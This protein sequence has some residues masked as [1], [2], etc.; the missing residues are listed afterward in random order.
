MWISDVFNFFNFSNIKRYDG[1]TCDKSSQ[2]TMQK[3]KVTADLQFHSDPGTQYMS[4]EYFK[5]I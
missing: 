1:E 3:E 2:K 4:H 5:I